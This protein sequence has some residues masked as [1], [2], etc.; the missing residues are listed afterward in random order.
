VKK[1]W[2]HGVPMWD[3]YK[4][5]KFT[6]KTIIS[7]TI[8]HHPALF[9]MS[10]QIKGKTICVVCLDGT[11]S[12]YLRGSTKTVYMG[13]MHFLLKTH[14]YR[15]MIDYFD[16]TNEK[17]FT[18]QPATATKVFEMCQKVKFKLDKKSK[19]GVDNMKRG[20][21][22]AEITK[23]VEVPFKKMSI[24]FKYLPYWKDLVVHHGIGGMHLQNKMCLPAPLDSWA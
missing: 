7:I 1:L 14:K 2:E 5:E 18:L 13:H 10:S 23:N 20:R 17:G 3:E 11:I 16:E 15:K 9:S 6:F 12:V 21:K 24:F 22:E 4:Q 19:G 8:N